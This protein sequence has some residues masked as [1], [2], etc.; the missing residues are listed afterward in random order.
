MNKPSTARAYRMV[1]RAEAAART[2]EDILAATAAL[3]REGG[4]DEIT[5]EAIAE[6][7]GVS[8]RTVLR[9]F[10]SRDGVIGATIEVEGVKIDAE[11]GRAVAGDVDGALDVLLGHYERDGDPVLRNLAVEGRVAEAKAVA[12]QGRAAHRAWCA[13]VFA[14]HLP[15]PEEPD[16]ATRLDALVAAT[17]LYLWKLLRRD[18]GRSVEETRRVLRMLIDGLLEDLTPDA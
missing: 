2:A 12:E 9:R 8:T 4:F 6:R 16:Y 7:A 15:S 1:A 13:R 10:G 5:L 14:P 18:L 17:D 11:R 3:W